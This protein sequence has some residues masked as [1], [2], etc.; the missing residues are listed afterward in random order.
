MFN[1][2]RN[3]DFDRFVKFAYYTGAR[4]GEIRHIQPQNLTDGSLVAFE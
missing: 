2:I 1:E 4:S 3:N